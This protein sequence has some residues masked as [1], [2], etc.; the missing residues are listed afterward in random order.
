MSGSVILECSVEMRAPFHDVDAMQVVWHGNYLKYFENAR[1]RLFEQV[2]VDL[3]EYHARSGYLFP[4]TRTWTKHV[5]PLRYNE[6]FTCRARLVDCHRKLVVE[7]EIRRATDGRICA[8]GGSEQVAIR[9]SDFRLEI[10]IPQDIKEAVRG[11]G[12]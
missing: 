12:P 9:S 3:F 4:I 8:K 11:G 10:E 6:R 1:E 2:G 7:Y 5:R